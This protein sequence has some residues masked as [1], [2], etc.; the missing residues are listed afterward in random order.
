MPP[1]PAER[2]ELFRAFARALFKADMDALYRVVAPE[3]VWS[4]HDGLMGTKVLSRPEAI[5]AHLEAQKAFYAS[6][7]F[8]DVAYHHLADTTFMTMSVSETVRATGE[9]REQRGI[10]R[11]T[12]AGGLIAS[13]DVYRKPI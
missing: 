4:Y 6:Q 9:Q 3:F 13:K 10:E 11:Y 8:H 12:F 1:S 7:R 5:V 2:E